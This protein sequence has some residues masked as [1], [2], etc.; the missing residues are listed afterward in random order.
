VNIPINLAEEVL[1][2]SNKASKK[3]GDAEAS[4]DLQGLVW[5][6]FADTTAIGGCR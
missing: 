6:L 5:K 2:W 4:P 1:S 3:T